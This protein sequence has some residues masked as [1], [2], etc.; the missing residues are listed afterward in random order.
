MWDIIF[1][2][3]SQGG[4]VSGIISHEVSVV[5][6]EP[7]EP[8]DRSPVERLR[9]LLDGFHFFRIWPASVPVNHES[10]ERLFGKTDGTLAGFCTQPSRFETVE[11]H[12]QISEVLLERP[13][14]SQQV[15]H[16]DT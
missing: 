13:V 15:I 10:E 16:V 2:E 3:G 1:R 7:Q 5:A 6:G 4:C 8:L 11:H 9:E 14:V 12:F